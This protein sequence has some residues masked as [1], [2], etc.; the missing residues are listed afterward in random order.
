MSSKTITQT[1]H[2]KRRWIIDYT[3]E[4]MKF[5]KYKCSKK[6]NT[7]LL[8]CLPFWIQQVQCT[9]INKFYKSRH[10][11]VWNN[12]LWNLSC[13]ESILMDN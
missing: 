6:E 8:S 2:N 12:A 10:I 9:R 7:A 5:V 3:K 1:Q 11:G 13:T 4:E